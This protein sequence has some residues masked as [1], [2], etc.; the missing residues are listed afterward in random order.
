ME[1]RLGTRR[2]DLEGASMLGENGSLQ[3]AGRGLIAAAL[4]ALAF[5]LFALAPTAAHA[6]GCTDSWTN[7]AGGSWFTGS[8]WSKEAPPAAGEEACITASGTY[9]VT[10]TQ[11]S[12]TVSLSALTVGGTSGTQTLVVGSSCSVD[13][14]FATTAGLSV[15][16]QGAV[17]LTNGDGC[18]D[19]VTLTG[20]VTNA[21]TLTSEPA[22]GGGRSIQG[23]VTNTGTLA[24]N[25]NTSFNGSSATLT[26]QGPL[27]VAAGKELS[28][29]S[30]NTFVNGTGSSIVAA[31]AGGVTLSGATFTQGAGTTSGTEPVIDDD[32]ALKYSGG[33]KSFVALR[34]TSTLSG[35]LDAVQSLAIQ[36]T[37]GENASVTA[38]KS[39]SSAGT[40]TLTNGDGCGD[41][42]T[43]VI[44]EG[45]FTNTGK[46]IT[47]PAHGGSRSLQGSIKN[48]GVIS[49][50]AN[51]SYNGTAATLTNEGALN[52]A[53]GTQLAVS[54]E[55]T[56][57]NGTGGSIAASGGSDVAL[58]SGTFFTA[59]AGTT[60]GTKP[61]IVDDGTLTY[62]GGGGGLIALHGTSKLSGSLGAEQTLSI[63]S[64]CSENATATAAASFTNAGTIKLTNGDGCGDSAALAIS[65]G[66]LTN[67]GKLIAEHAINGSRTVQGNLVNTGTLAFNTNTAYN[68]ASGTL[69]NEG[70]LNIAEGD[71][72]DVSGNNTLVNGAGG[73]IT[74]PGG[75]YVSM[76]GGTT[77]T[78]GAG[79]TTGAKP[80]VVDDGTLDYTGTGASTIALHGTSTVN[81]SIGAEQVLVI[82]S[83]CSEN[84]SAELPASATNAGTI[85][86]TNGDSCGNS[87]TLDTETGTLTNS[88]KIVTEV[89]V[90]GS[91]TL[92]GN[93]TNTGTITTKG[94]TAYTGSG[95]LLTNSGTIDVAEGTQLSVTGG[96]VTNTGTGNIFAPGSALFYQ[97]GGTFTELSGKTS[98]TVP[99]VIDDGALKYESTSAE[100]GSGPIALR[101]ASTVS[102][103]VR[104]G[105]TLILQS[106]CSE[107]ATITDASSLESFGLIEMTNG[108]GCGNSATLTLKEGAGTLTNGGTLSILE[109]HGGSR[110]IVG[111]LVNKATVSLAAAA[112]LQV[113]GTYTQTSAGQLRSFIGG[114]SEFGSM[115]VS[116]AATIAGLASPRKVGTFKPTL[117]QAFAILN[118]AS[119]SGSFS[120]EAGEPQIEPGLYYQ[121]AYSATSAS[122]VA[123]KVTLSLS[124]ASGAPGSS[125]T[126]S[127][128]GYVPGDTVTLTFTDKAGVKTT[129]ATPTVGSGGEY[130]TEVAVPTGAAVGTGTI[131][132]SATHY[133]SNLFANFKVT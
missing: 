19:S 109:P 111:G 108:D 122:L 62:T 44:A 130:S 77:F 82:E 37:C 118:A 27:D 101:G 25:T 38:S 11:E 75:A 33:G 35:N 13:A 8:N 105:N 92:E 90:N 17:T 49:V 126:V 123:A 115:T 21:G 20:P 3:T 29:S 52:L 2:D 56:V 67:T 72:L 99:V 26:N 48:A 24:I 76:Q 80:V 50:K 81:G 53:E 74:A 71:Q 6:S 120:G 116:G 47:E 43:L 54:A 133:G 93:L 86:L 83:T 129:L 114:A 46:L 23:N 57:V 94:N 15:G 45:T 22:S 132:A 32:G 64:T 36:S 106:T 9:T 68:G 112:H 124:A 28:V 104:T 16:A 30:K 91:R 59:G 42:A 78:E 7:T 73:N 100:P 96:S 12:G 127:G 65:E 34:G 31:G 1:T 66:T 14:I 63:E 60:S 18:G 41:S 51:T 61:V 113:N 89:P 84:A 69:T 125:L 79:T 4:L 128:S 102:G 70:A 98:G 58:G 39:F 85:K 95:E 110:T 107:N 119:L 87:A 88:G 5:G 103:R 117:G 131:K 55:G 121:P 97:V 10:M 40:V